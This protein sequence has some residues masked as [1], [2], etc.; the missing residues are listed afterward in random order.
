MNPLYTEFKRKFSLSMYKNLKISLGEMSFFKDF[1]NNERGDL[2]PVT[3]KSDG[4]TETVGNNLYTVKN[5]YT[6]RLFCQFFPF[7][8]YEVSA[9]ITDGKVGF[10]FQLADTEAKICV[11]KS[12]LKYSCAESTAE[13]KLPD[14]V[15]EEFTLIVS[16]RP[17]AFDV[18]FKN[19]GK[20][21]YCCT[22]Y[23][24]RFKNS[25]VY[26]VFS[27]SYVLLYVKG[28][29]T[30]KEVLSY[31]DNGVSIADIRPVRYENGEVITQQGKIWF[32]ASVRMQ[33][34]SFQ[35]VFSWLPG[36]AQFNMTGALFYDCGDGV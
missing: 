18:Y 15:S 21:E 11:S 3:E 5:G 2:Y 28:D 30:V 13:E 22:F 12:A 23:E 25:N 10:C 36:T 27:S 14:F 32:T 29:A 33:E 9:D 20:A 35:G 4:C 7:A 16:C 6:K 8:T 24:E 31:I 19:S 1:T 34:G 17:G 26:N